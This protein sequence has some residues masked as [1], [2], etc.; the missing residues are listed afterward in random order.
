MSWFETEEERATREHNVGQETGS[1]AGFFER[2]IQVNLGS[3]VSSEEYNAGYKNGMNNP[4]K[5]DSEKDE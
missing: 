1:K 5:P 3:I 2:V 4:S